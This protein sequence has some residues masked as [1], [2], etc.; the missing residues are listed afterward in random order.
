MADENLVSSILLAKALGI[1]DS[2]VRQLVQSG[3]FPKP[4]KV[5]RVN[6]YDW[7]ECV[8]IYIEYKV[9]NPENQQG[10]DKEKGDYW[11]EKTRLTKAQANK[12]ELAVA[13]KK[14]E[15]VNAQEICQQYSSYILACRSKLLSLPTKMAYELVEISNPNVIKGKLE[16]VI[17]EALL[18]LASAEFVEKSQCKSNE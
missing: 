17:D 16:L 6:K 2:R 15:L 9:K 13:E 1:D 12:E 7:V 3:V 18:E 5:G 14:G 8:R 11:T 10:D 4:K